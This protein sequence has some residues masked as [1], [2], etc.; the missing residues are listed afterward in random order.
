MNSTIILTIIVLS[1]LGVGAAILLFFISKKFNVIEDPKIDEVEKMLPGANCGGCGFPGCRKFATELVTQTSID[2]LFCA[3]AGSE[4]M[5]KIADF[6][7]KSV[8]SKKAQVA[9]VRCGGSPS[10]RKKTSEYDGAKTCKKYSQGFTVAIPVVHT[11]VWAWAI[12]LKS[13]NLM[14]FISM[15]LPHCPK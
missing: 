5:S 7:G 8:Q 9:V 13:A 12:V 3:P 6:L 1:T 15:K 14:Q 10:H 2:H 4:V 11:A